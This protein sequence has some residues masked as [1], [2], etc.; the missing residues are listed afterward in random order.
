MSETFRPTVVIEGRAPLPGQLVTRQTYLASALE[1]EG[2]QTFFVNAQDP[3]AYDAAGRLRNL[4]LEPGQYAW[5]LRDKT[6][7]NGD[8]TAY[9]DGNDYNSSTARTELATREDFAKT[10]Q[11][12]GLERYGIPL[13][14]ASDLKDWELD[15]FIFVKPNRVN[16]I[17]GDAALRARRV[18]TVVLMANIIET[19]ED[20]ILQRPE[21]LLDAGELVGQLGTAFSI[22]RDFNYLHALRIFTPLWLPVD[23]TPAVELRLT[24]TRGDIGKQFASQLQLLE[25]EHVFNRPRS[26]RYM[27]CYEMPLLRGTVSKT[28]SHLTTLCVTMAP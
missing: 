28:T 7:Q 26:R 25:P 16:D 14:R 15:E 1:A 4:D 21:Q 22:D 10:L 27:T 9:P 11:V 19:E 23:Q 8:P 3:E 17:S 18:K 20:M 2:M 12:L 5:R 6:W 13:Q 24:D